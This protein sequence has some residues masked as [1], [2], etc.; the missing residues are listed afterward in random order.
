MDVQFFALAK[1]PNST[2]RPNLTGGSTYTDIH[3]KGPCSIRTPTIKIRMSSGSDPVGFNYCYIDDFERYYFVNDW[4]NENYNWYAYLVEDELATWKDAIGSSTQYILRSSYSSDGWIKDE[5][6]P[7][8]GSVNTFTDTAN[9]GANPYDNTYPTTGSLCYVIGVINND[10]NH[11]TARVGA[12]CYYAVTP[13]CMGSIMAK[14][15][16]PGGLTGFVAGSDNVSDAVF[17]SIYDPAQYIVSCMF[18][19]IT[20]NA[21]DACTDMGY[22]P[23]ALTG[24]TGCYYV[25]L[26][27]LPAKTGSLS[28][29][30][31]PQAATRG[32]YLNLGPFT[33]YQIE[34]RPFGWIPIDPVDVQGY[35]TLYYWICFDPV[36]GSANLILSTDSA[37][38]RVVYEQSVM[39][40]VPIQLAQMS[41]DYASAAMT[42]VGAIAG[43]AAGIGMGNIPGAIMSGISGIGNAALSTIPQMQTQGANGSFGELVQA[44]IKMVSR[45][46]ILVDDDNADRGRPLCKKATISSYPGYLVIADPD[47]SI[48]EAT[49]EEMDAIKNYM[50][51]GFFYE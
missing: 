4:V 31:H 34:I 24:L 11:P 36:S 12:V 27:E 32:N 1:R 30:K 19:P 15:M 22:G 41:R 39:L 33:K 25:N 51:S 49:R 18:C 8:T 10:Q 47:V 44:K 42:T 38:D 13:A 40:G 9:S 3:L 28:I 17:K 5:L 16:D 48:N 7:A 45:F 35:S 26:N 50:A 6:Y 23:F 21:T 46:M 14:L 20:P 29:H 2:A 37:Y 43:V